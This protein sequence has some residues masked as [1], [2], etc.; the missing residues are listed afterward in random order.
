MGSRHRRR[1]HRQ[2]P[3]LRSLD[4][5]DG[6]GSRGF[7]GCRSH[8]CHCHQGGAHRS[9]T[10]ECHHCA[11]GHRNGS[12]RTDVPRP[13]D[14]NIYARRGGRTDTGS[15]QRRAIGADN[16]VYRLRRSRAY[17]LCTPAYQQAPST[18]RRGSGPGSPPT[19]PLHRGTAA[20]SIAAK[21]PNPTKDKRQRIIRIIAGQQK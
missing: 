17:N 11:L 21:P 4:T 3:H 2:H 5:G 13:D 20:L 14:N 6:P 15:V 18:A 12:G 19:Q 1:H 10:D 9:C 16:L 7:R 8:S